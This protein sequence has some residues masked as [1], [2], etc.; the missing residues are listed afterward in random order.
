MFI[1]FRFYTKV[2][3]KIHQSYIKDIFFLCIAYD[4]SKV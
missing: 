1:M 3:I 4:C 2:I